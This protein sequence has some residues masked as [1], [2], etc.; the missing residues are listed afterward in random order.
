[1]T[2]TTTT[3]STTTIIAITAAITATA[4]A[5]LYTSYIT[6][7]TKT[8]RKIAARHTAILQALDDAAT[9]TRTFGPGDGWLILVDKVQQIYGDTARE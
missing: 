5:L 6:H 8:A 7:I 3:M 4:T 1:M 2:T 9:I